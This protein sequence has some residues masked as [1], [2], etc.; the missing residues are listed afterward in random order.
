MQN[1]VYNTPT[2]VVFGKN[3]VEMTGEL[4]FEQG[5]KKAL[6][7]YGGG[8]AV[9][10]GLLARVLASLD[11]AG[12]GHAELGGV[13]PNPRLSKVREGIEL[14]QKEGVDFLLAIGG[15]SVID[16]AKG[17][18]Y[19][20]CH[21][22]D[23]WDLFCGRAKPTA[24]APIGCVLTIAAAGSEM[25]NA[26]VIT[27]EDGGL[28]RGVRC[29]VVRPKFAVLDPEL[30]LTLPAYHTANGAVDIMMHTM[31]RY[32]TTEK[33]LAL[34]DAIAEGLLRCVM[35]SAATLC[36]NPEDYAARADMMWASSISHN[37]LT[38]C[39]GVEDWACHQLEHELSG[40]FDCAHGAGLAAVW[41][42]WARYVAD[43]NPARF[44]QF[45]VNVMG[46]SR[47]V[48]DRETAE[49]G[50]TAVENFYH[51]I[52]MPANIHELGY[53]LSEDQI[54]ELTRKCTF[55][56]TR[57]IGAF[58]KLDEADIT[59]IYKMACA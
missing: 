24:A 51:S 4:V 53:D 54:A 23:V 15:G 21:D 36:R 13:V 12:I 28:K 40:M 5:V 41:G 46:E 34:T 27:N 1:F 33:G 3:T 47:G 32:F 30:T 58:K 18:A 6:V 45:A 39:G 7:I 29:D 37:G 59:K 50:I 57:S 16:T 55:F 44:A 38:G 42:A 43:E 2:K 17:V 26:T 19:G 31:E 9:K 20:L 11:A 48:D 10:S 22:G 52:G 14:S 25:S 8:S 56:G 35:E 49:R